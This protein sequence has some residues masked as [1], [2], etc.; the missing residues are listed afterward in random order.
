MVKI[1]SKNMGTEKEL[2]ADNEIMRFK[3]REK[4]K[5][6]LWPEKSLWPNVVDR[7]NE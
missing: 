7:E 6:S 1:Y 4:K 3:F 5:K 2:Y